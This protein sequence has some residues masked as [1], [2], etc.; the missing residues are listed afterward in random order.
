MLAFILPVAN[1]CDHP[2]L[3][4]RGI[5]IVIEAHFLGKLV[6]QPVALNH[7]RSYRQVDPRLC[8]IGFFGL[9]WS[10]LIQVLGIAI[11]Y[12]KQTLLIVQVVLENV[13]KHTFVTNCNLSY[14]L[15]DGAPRLR[16]PR[17]GGSRA[18]ACR[19]STPAQE[20]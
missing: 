13:F 8:P 12:G 15:P 17:A 14:L 6:V 4:V 3:D 19:W 10:I 16:L 7:D 9:V 5:W 18:Q 2:F 1:F 20:H 11:E